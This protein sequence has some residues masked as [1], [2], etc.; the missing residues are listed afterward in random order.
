MHFQVT[1][2]I[3]LKI[4]KYLH[5][6]QEISMRARGENE[7]QIELYSSHFVLFFIEFE[8]SPTLTQQV[9]Q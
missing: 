8:F 2:T 7:R 5:G 9:S 4:L 1:K 3:K 6:K